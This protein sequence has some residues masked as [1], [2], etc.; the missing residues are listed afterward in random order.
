MFKLAYVPESRQLV[1]EYELPTKDV[2]PTVKSYRYVKAT[3]SITE[4]ERPGSQVKSLYASVVA[5][6]TLRTV[7]ELFSADGGRHVD[8]VVVNGIVDTTHRG[9]GQRIRPCLVTLR[10]T[11]DTFSTLGLSRVD[12]QECL[13]YLSASVSKD[14]AEL[15]PVR[16]VLEFDMVDPRFIAETDALSTLESRP[17]LMEL[18][19][20]EFEALIQ[21]LFTKMGLEVAPDARVPR[22]RRRLCRLRPTSDH[23]RQGRH[24]GQAVP[25]H[26]GRVRRARPVRHPAERRREQGHPRHNQWVRQCLVRV[27]PRQ[28]HRTHR[29]GELLYLLAEH[30]GIQARIVPPEDWA[31]PIPDGVLRVLSPSWAV[32]GRLGRLAGGEPRVQS[33]RRRLAVEQL[34]GFELGLVAAAMGGNTVDV[35]GLPPVSS[36]W[37]GQAARIRWIAVFSAGVTYSPYLAFTLTC[38]A[39]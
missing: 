28:A 30:A 6:T 21:N 13:K 32:P 14:P 2:V 11:R 23:G 25:A 4:T 39:T 20:S 19:P 38:R 16:P 3:D 34:V 33:S 8:T 26:G 9:T 10:T 29:R 5:Q 15:A 12:P 24:S 1:C 17:N 18:T 27:R 37:L 36:G 22:W 7:H 35:V 31:D